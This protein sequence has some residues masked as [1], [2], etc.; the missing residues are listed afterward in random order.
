[1]GRPRSPPPPRAHHLPPPGHAPRAAAQRAAPSARPF[2]RSPRLAGGGRGAHARLRLAAPTPPPPRPR[3]VDRELRRRLL[4]HAPR[5]HPPGLR[6]LP[7]APG[8]RARGS[9]KPPL[10]GRG[11]SHRHRRRGRREVADPP[12]G[13]PLA[14]RLAVDGTV[15]PGGGGVGGAGGARMDPPPRRGP[16]EEPRGLP[17]PRRRAPACGG[18]PLRPGRQPDPREPGKDPRGDPARRL[19]ARRGEPPARAPGPGPRARR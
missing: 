9:P 17:R 15:P 10:G 2:L 19:R 1:S 7:P 3:L 8:P 13:H 5:A 16:L 6:L 18:P 14:P 12:H 4:D 11:G